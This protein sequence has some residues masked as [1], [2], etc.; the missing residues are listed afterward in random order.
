MERV[1][2][3]T[4]SWLKAATTAFTF[5]TLLRHYA[6]QALT[7]QK[8]DVIFGCWHNLI[9]HLIILCDYEPSCWPS[10]E[11][12]SPSVW[13][14]GSPGITCRPHPWPD[15]RNNPSS[16]SDKQT[17]NIHGYPP[18]NWDNRFSSRHFAISPPAHLRQPLIYSQ[19][20]PW[21]ILRL[22]AA[23]PNSALFPIIDNPPSARENCY[24]IATSHP[25]AH[26]NTTCIS[27]AFWLTLALVS[28]SST[29]ELMSQ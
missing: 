20:S 28:I 5:K 27:C 16:S 22:F 24:L 4:K 10:F 18:S 17:Q 25:S 21:N 7:P 3:R 11:A 6:K 26:N 29:A 15:I 12:L 19:Y 13:A 9:S 23:N 1:P 2:T 8:V 14:G